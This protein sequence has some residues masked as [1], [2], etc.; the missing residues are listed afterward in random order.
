ML[1]GNPSGQGPGRGCAPDLGIRAARVRCGEVC[2][3][4]GCA[5]CSP[6]AARQEID[7]ME[8]MSLVSLIAALLAVRGAFTTDAAGDSAAC[9]TPPH[10]LPPHRSPRRRAW[11]GLPPPKQR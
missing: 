4:P 6:T 3:S 10:I 2:M 5:R 1:V 8:Q 7:A 9:F 11:Q